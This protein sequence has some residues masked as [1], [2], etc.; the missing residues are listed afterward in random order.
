MSEEPGENGVPSSTGQGGG[1]RL[2]GFQHQ[3]RLSLH[4]CSFVFLPYNLPNTDTT[5]EATPNTR[6]VC[7]CAW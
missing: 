5:A 2:E 6:F 3:Q 1:G 4:V 7:A